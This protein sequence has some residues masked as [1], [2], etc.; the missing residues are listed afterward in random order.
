MYQ[1]SVS[2][3]LAPTPPPRKADPSYLSKASTPPMFHPPKKHSPLGNGAAEN[4]LLSQSPTSIPYCSTCPFLQVHLPTANDHQSSQSP[5]SPYYTQPLI[6]FPPKEPTHQSTLYLPQQLQPSQEHGDE[7]LPK[8][9]LSPEQE[10]QKQYLDNYDLPSSETLYHLDQQLSGVVSCATPYQ[11]LEFTN[12]QKKPIKE[13]IPN[14]LEVPIP[15]SDDPV[16]TNNRKSYEQ[17]NG[18]KQLQPMPMPQLL[19]VEYPPGHE[20]PSCCTC[21]SIL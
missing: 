15:D 8:K 5:P 19:S 7:S 17:P 16:T 14:P 20:P 21:C 3:D 1:P 2:P 10:G 13:R 9:L 18:N 11:E 6:G 4:S 12:L